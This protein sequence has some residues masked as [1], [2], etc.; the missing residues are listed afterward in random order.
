MKKKL[1]KTNLF[2]LII[3]SLSS[4]IVISD[5]LT[6]TITTFIG[7][8]SGWTWFGFIS[9]M[10]AFVLLDLSSRYLDSIKKEK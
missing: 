8:T 3:F 5:L 6:I 1:N 9:F 7:K 2:M 10:A 4:L